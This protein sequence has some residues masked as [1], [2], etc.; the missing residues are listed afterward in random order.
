MIC[1]FF[2]W[3]VLLIS[4]LRNLCPKS[5]DEKLKKNRCIFPP[6]FF[7][8]LWLEA[9]KNKDLRGW[10]GCKMKA[11]GDLFTAWRRVPSQERPPSW[12]WSQKAD[13]NA[14]CVY[15]TNIVGLF[16]MVGQPAWNLYL[17][18]CADRVLSLVIPSRVTV[19]DERTTATNHSSLFLNVPIDL[20]Q[21]EQTVNSEEDLHTSSLKC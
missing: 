18:S 13:R 5:L 19:N 6:S 16:V 10:R 15:T 4:C 2:W 12:D 21:R 7:L 14:C 9:D 11:V 3:F 17:S 8:I 20:L 1:Q